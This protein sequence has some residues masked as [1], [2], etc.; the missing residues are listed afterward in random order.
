MILK[1]VISISENRG[2][3]GSEHPLC[4]KI[5]LIMVILFFIVWGIDTISFFIF[6]YSTVIVG[7]ISFPVLILPASVFL[8]LSLY[9]VAKSHNAV[10]SGT[11]DH[12][13]LLDSGVYAWVR[14]PMYL[15]TLLFCLGF[16]FLSPSLLSLGIWIAFFIIYDKMAT[17]EEN[18]LV[19]VLGKEYNSYQNR[20]SKWFPSIRTLSK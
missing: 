9:L 14:H 11:D 5:Q 2:C 18:D 8:C 4:D 6:G 1:V 3:L 13:K 20:V 19:K 10:F 16:F 17:Y 7:L 12:P 15:G